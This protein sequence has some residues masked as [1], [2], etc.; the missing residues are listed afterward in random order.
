MK[1]T[2]RQFTASA[3][4]LLLNA[5]QVMA[6]NTG[7]GEGDES[8]DI[9]GTIN[10]PKGVDRYGS[11]TEGG[12]ILFVS[13]IIRISTVVAGIWVMFNFIVAGWKYISST[14]DN[15]A[16]AEASEMMTH[17]LIGLAIIVGAYTLAALVGLLFFGDAT[18]IINPKLTGAPA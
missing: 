2:L 13:N 6:Q 16:P 4:L 12:L 1:K 5:G 18:Y 17:S 7:S 8:A 10:A 15:K 3:S 9:F 14:G 11:A